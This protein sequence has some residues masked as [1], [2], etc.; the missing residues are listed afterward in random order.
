MYVR[1]SSRKNKTGQVVRYLQL[2]HNEWDPAAGMSRT[3]VLYSF[4]REDEPDRPAVQRLVTA[5]SRLLDPTA[6]AALTTPT[7]MTLTDSRPMGGAYALDGLWRALGI[8]AAIRDALAGKRADATRVERILFALTANRVLKPSSKL[9]ATDWIAHDVHIDGLDAVVDE[10]CYRA[11]DALL[12]VE[13]LVA[14]QVYHQV[15]DLLNLEVDLLFFDTSSTYF[16]TGEADTPVARDGHGRVRRGTEPSDPVRD[17]GFRT[18]GKSMDHRDDLPQVVVGMA[19]TRTGIPLR[20]WSWPG[21]YSDSALIRQV[22]DDMRDWSLARVIWVADRGFS[23]AENRRYLQRA[24]G[25]YIIGEKLPSGSAEATAALSRQGR[26]AQIAANLQVKEVKLDD[27]GDRF[28]ICFNPDEA[29]RDAHVREHLLARL[30]DKITGSDAL[31]ATKRAELRGQISTS[32]GLNRFLRVTPGGLLRL[33]QAAIKAEARL[34]G[35]YLLRCSDP[36]LTPEASPWA[37]SNS[38]KSNAAGA[39]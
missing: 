18:H 6:A 1:V 27:T 35:K 17:S 32:P 5:L 3:K 19:V 4:G 30:T 10:A 7:D 26:Y 2:A 37:T 25:H 16:E 28:V 36:K 9:A 8:D 11:M 22:K 34:D 38:S 31:P 13:A 21:N 24:G 23:S 29:E 14:R 12:G 39:T 15:A 33:D 20:V